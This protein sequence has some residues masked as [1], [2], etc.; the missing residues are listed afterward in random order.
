MNIKSQSD[1]YKRYINTLERGVENAQYEVDKYQAIVAAL[2]EKSSLFE[3]YLSQAELEKTQALILKNLTEE[4]FQKITDLRDRS[5]NVFEGTVVAKQKT[6]LLNAAFGKVTEQLIYT[7]GFLNELFVNIIRSKAKNPLISN[8]LMDAVSLAQ[9]KNIEVISQA[10]KVVKPVVEAQQSI[11]NAEAISS[12]EM[13]SA[14]LL[15][16]TYSG[17]GNSDNTPIHKNTSLLLLVEQFFNLAK[18]NFEEAQINVKKA[19]KELSI[20]KSALEN[21]EIKFQSLEAGLAAAIAAG[22]G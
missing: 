21:A 8:D 2:T 10:L 3:S 13:E 12:L 6:N 9:Q 17:K 16:K 14:Q 22:A 5:K 11:N 15:Y 19:N 18:K 20:A 1:H 7:S 4:T